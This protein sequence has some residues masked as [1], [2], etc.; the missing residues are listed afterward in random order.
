MRPSEVGAIEQRLAAIQ[1]PL[2]CRVAVLS[3][4]WTLFVTSG[5]VLQHRTALVTA[6]V[7]RV[8]CKYTAICL[9]NAAMG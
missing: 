8:T 2:A 1:R 9:T 6:V 4:S 5:H 3:L 7:R